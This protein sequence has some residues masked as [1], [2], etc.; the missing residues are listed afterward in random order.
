MSEIVIRKWGHIWHVRSDDG[1]TTT[2]SFTDALHWA[3]DDLEP[4]GPPVSIRWGLP[5]PEGETP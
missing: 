5:I 4:G 3:T 1:S 2:G